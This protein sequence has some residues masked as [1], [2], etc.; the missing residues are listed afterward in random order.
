MISTQQYAVKHRYVLRFFFAV[1][2]IVAASWQ[3]HAATFVVDRADDPMTGNYNGCVSAPNDCSLRGAIQ[4]A[5]SNGPGHDVIEFRI[6]GGGVKVIQLTDALPSILTSVTITGATQSGYFGKPMVQID[7]A[8]I[9]SNGFLIKTPAATEIS[10]SIIALSITNHDN[11]VYALCTGRCDLT[12]LGN[13][14]GVDPTGNIAMGNKDNGVLID[15]TDQ[16]IYTIGGPG[17]FEGN[18]ISGN[19]PP[20]EDFLKPGFFA[21]I[22]VRPY[23]TGGASAGSA[24]VK[25][26]GNKIGTNFDGTVDL[27]NA[28]T[29]IKV[30]ERDLVT[31]AEVATLSVV[32]GGSTVGHRNVISGNDNH[33]IYADV[34][35]LTLQ[36]NYIGLNAAGSGALANGA[37]GDVPDHAVY[38]GA[39][40]NA[41]YLI[42]G[43]GAGEGNVISGNRGSGIG[44]WTG[45]VGS[46]TTQLIVVGNHIGTNP[47]GTAAIANK[48]DGIWI[49]FSTKYTVNAVIGGATTGSRNVISGNQGDGIMIGSGHV[50]VYG[51]H[52][53]TNNDGSAAI[54]NSNNGVL[55]SHGAVA[56]IG[57]TVVIG[58][59][60]F[61]GGNVISGN[62]KN[63]VQISLHAVGNA[64]V[65][66]NRIGTNADGTHAMPNMLNGIFA[67]GNG[68]LIGS[69]TSAADRNLISGNAMAGILIEG[70]NN[71]VFGNRIG[72]NIAGGDFLPN[73][74]GIRI[75]DGSNNQIGLGGNNI[76]TNM[77]SGNNG[78]GIHIL[79]N[80]ANG[81][82]IE[83]NVIGLSVVGSLGNQ[84]N[85][86]LIEGSNSNNVV[87][88]AAGAGNIIAFNDN[89]VWLK[90][91]V[92]N[93]VRRNSIYTNDNYGIAKGFVLGNGNGYPILQTANPNS[94]LGLLTGS[95]GTLFEIDFFRVDSCNSSGFGEGR[96]YLGSSSVVTDASGQAQFTSPP[97]SLSVGQ[98]VTATATG[99]QTSG[100]S[101]CLQ[102]TAVP[103]ISFSN[104][105]YSANEGAGMRTISVNRT[106]GTSDTITVDY[107]TSDGTANAG[108][109]YVAASGTLTFNSGDVVKTFN[110]QITEDATDEADETVNLTL[111]N[112]QGGN[113]FLG[114][115]STA[116]LTINDNDDPPSISINDVSQNEGDSGTTTFSFQVQLSVASAQEV[117]VAYATADGTATAPF[118]YT[119]AN[120][121]LNFAPG[122]TNK[123]INVSVVADD[124][125][126][127]DET[128]FVN[129]SNPMNAT[130]GDAQGLGTIVNDDTSV[131]PGVS[132]NSVAMA[133][134]NAGT[135][136]FQ[137]TVQLSTASVNTVTVDYATEDGTASAPDDYISANGSIVFAPG[138]TTMSLVIHVVGDT[139]VEDD[140]R[141]IV[142]LVTASNATV[143]VGKGVGTILND[144][145]GS[146]PS[147]TPT[148]TPNPQEWGTFGQ[149]SYGSV[150]TSFLRT[151]HMYDGFVMPNLL[152]A[153]LGDPLFVQPLPPIGPYPQSL[154][155]GVPGTRSLTIPLSGSQ[156]II[157]RLAATG[158]TS[159]LPNFGAGGRPVDRTLDASTCQ[160]PNEPGPNPQEKGLPLSNKGKFDNVL[161]GQTIALALNMRLDPNLANFNLTNIGKVVTIKGKPYRQFTTQGINPDGSLIEDDVK[162]FAIPQSVI[163]ALS[164]PALVGADNVGKVSGLLI[165]A[166]RGLAGLSTGTASLNDIN[167]G[168]K[169]INN[170]FEMCRVLIDGTPIQ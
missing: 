25:I 28:R 13:F 94:I 12:L 23:V 59:F 156:C 42:G 163:D 5:N 17:I 75:S 50:S 153:L 141:F 167:V 158:N 67:Q 113:A 8:G 142:N 2:F 123:V 90:W 83:N 10:V 51:N 11:G 46:G 58:G 151:G 20:G 127:A 93:R 60:S 138:E 147:P 105:S 150:D 27:G 104:A 137:F 29:G 4:K 55:V 154:E 111:S 36:G 91:A 64:Q 165:L 22:N 101:P 125:Q 168:A 129:L 78:D 88:G 128:F 34:S 32:I 9:S 45:N 131:S 160:V 133:E 35:S 14:I 44:V 155:L 62:K 41:S 134:G 39:N 52:I 170:G 124:N 43:I 146:T 103:S 112:V 108:Q 63:G 48:G 1:C 117:S 21:G 26:F 47:T 164:D 40:P 139:V 73:G 145:E 72:T 107:A 3:A 100:F 161:L 80:S 162:N 85:G 49:D 38:L 115:P 132:I 110:V 53:G 95:P 96:Y 76:A 120:G 135:T 109:D 92:P 140:E 56:K 30:S 71:K 148:P 7:G 19:G 31:E 144:D 33:G 77:I 114:S 18:V 149:S 98:V 118:D 121:V 97:V 82:K 102:V 143:D 61:D 166:N 122:E 6:P 152:K 169:V 106:G 130:L 89:G 84:G 126:E 15:P 136:S 119:A 24:V 157:T 86:V 37:E 57:G 159:A 68:A 54:P 70:D 16:S 66:R 116:V 65:R 79:G 87:G 81:N 99:S 69:E 74:T